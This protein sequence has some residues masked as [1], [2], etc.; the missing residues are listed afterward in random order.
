M[1]V[2]Q[3]GAGRAVDEFREGLRKL[4]TEGQNLP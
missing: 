2:V 3:T 4:G 1:Y